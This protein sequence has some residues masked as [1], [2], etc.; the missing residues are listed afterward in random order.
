M[1]KTNLILILCSFILIHAAPQQKKYE[2]KDSFMPYNLFS[3][4]PNVPASDELP[5]LES[6]NKAVSK[7]IEFKTDE[8]GKPTTDCES[9][10][11]NTCAKQLTANDYNQSCKKNWK[12]CKSDVQL[13][14]TEICD[15]RYK[16]QNGAFLKTCF[17]N[18]SW[19]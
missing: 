15:K 4:G 17:Y 19:L 16:N 9:W 10:G 5:C 12:L 18:P 11:L 8:L 3:Y 13:S 2:K 6:D 7:C 1:K 14:S